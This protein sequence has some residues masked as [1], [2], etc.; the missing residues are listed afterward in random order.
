MSGGYPV[1]T[2]LH[3]LAG[4]NLSLLIYLYKLSFLS[5]RAQETIDRVCALL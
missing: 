4:H 3:K 1:S 5:G 2:E